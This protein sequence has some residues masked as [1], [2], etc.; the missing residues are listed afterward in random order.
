MSTT[1]KCRKCL[2]AFEVSI[3]SCDNSIQTQHNINITNIHYSESRKV[4]KNINT[5]HNHSL[6][7]LL[8]YFVCW[9]LTRKY[10][11]QIYTQSRFRIADKLQSHLRQLYCLIVSY[12]ERNKCNKCKYK[13]IPTHC[14]SMLAYLI[15]G[16]G[17]ISTQYH[18]IKQKSSKLLSH[19]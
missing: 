11:P 14:H 19:D 4:F 13:I 5:N 17:L 3:I 9:K 10:V 12:H 8:C 15:P 6:F 16:I 18:T 1:L 2:F 7:C